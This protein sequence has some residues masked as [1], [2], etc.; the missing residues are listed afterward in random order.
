V[1]VDGKAGRAREV[2]QN[3]L[4]SSDGS[5]VT[6]GQNECVVCVL[7]DRAWQVGVNRVHKIPTGGSATD[8][9]L[10]DICDDDETVWRERIALT[11][12][13]PTSDL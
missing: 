10:E 12:T 13:A 5:S 1:E 4:E 7:K 9:A 2:I 6:S 3:S 11:E 8:E